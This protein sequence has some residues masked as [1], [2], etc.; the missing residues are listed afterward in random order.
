[1]KRARVMHG[2]VLVGAG[3]AMLVD[4]LGKS[5]QWNLPSCH[6]SDIRRRCEQSTRRKPGSKSL[7]WLGETLVSSDKGSKQ[8]VRS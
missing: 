8:I 1:M 7:G 4:V 2:Q 5:R 3:A 6:R